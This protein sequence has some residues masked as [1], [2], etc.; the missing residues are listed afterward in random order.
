MLTVVGLQSENS[1]PQMFEVRGGVRL[2]G[3]DSVLFLL[4]AFLFLLLRLFLLFHPVFSRHGLG[5]TLRLVFFQG[6]P[7]WVLGDTRCEG[8]INHVFL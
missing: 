6:Y 2:E 8:N 3:Q 5:I 7:H 4:L 1:V